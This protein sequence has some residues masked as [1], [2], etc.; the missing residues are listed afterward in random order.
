MEDE[1]IDS[2]ML[3]W[4]KMI[5]SAIQFTEF[6]GQTKNKASNNF[7]IFQFFFRYSLSMIIT[8]MQ[9]FMSLIYHS[10]NIFQF[11]SIEIQISSGHTILHTT[12]FSH[13]SN[14]FPNTII[15]I[16]QKTFDIKKR[17]TFD[18]KKET[19]KTNRDDRED[20]KT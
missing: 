19:D 11:N 20:I 16:G 14:S 10:T 8:Y 6:T 3:N 2:A 4:W 13:N 12:P 15:A 9:Q 18:I 17:Q 7:L 1:K 5:D